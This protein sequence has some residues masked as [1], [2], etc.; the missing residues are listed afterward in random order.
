MAHGARATGADPR[1]PFV[2]ARLFA[3]RAGRDFTSQGSQTVSRRRP[4]HSTLPPA[5]RPAPAGDRLQKVLAAAGIGS[6]RECEELITGGRV[7]VDGAVVTEL[8]TRVDPLRQQVRVDGVALPHP[9]RVYYVLNKPPGVVCTNRDPSG[10]VQAVDLVRSDERLFTVGRL[11]RTSEG[12]IL[13]TNDGELANQLTHPRYGVDKRYLV[14]VAGS[15]DPL[16]FTRL[17]RG[18]YLAEG[19]ARVSDVRVRK[20]GSKYTDL[21]IALRE[22]RNREI[23]RMLA[24]VGHKILRLKRIAIGPLRLGEL[25]TGATRP[26]TRDELRKLQELARPASGRRRKGR[27]HGPVGRGGLRGRPPSQPPDPT[28]SRTLDHSPGQESLGTVLSFDAAPSPQW[29]RRTRKKRRP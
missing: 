10:R 12:L 16:L 7:E 4:R 13:V 11:D 14:R 15:P 23:R 1:R 19:V 28:D 8:G 29:P 2:S 21:E 22:G 3:G 20:R 9:K 18:I 27:P 6:R 5:S 26:L 24:R 25:P 17:R